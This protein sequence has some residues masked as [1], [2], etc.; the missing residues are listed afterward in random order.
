MLCYYAVGERSRYLGFRE[1]ERDVLNPGEEGNGIDYKVLGMF[2][3]GR[4]GI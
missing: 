2:W 3:K 1:Q 4:G